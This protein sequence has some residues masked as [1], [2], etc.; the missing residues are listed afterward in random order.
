[1]SQSI[2]GLA[3]QAAELLLEKK[4]ENVTILK[5]PKQVTLFNYFVIADALSTNHAQT[6][7][8]HI[9]EVMK[10]A[11][12]PVLALDGLEAGSWVLIDLGTVVVHIFQQPFREY[13]DLENLW[14][15]AKKIEI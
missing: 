5:L 7:G 4:G 1:M 2:I 15:D 13:Y 8:K 14:P 3:R 6:L 9:K 12:E 10:K 11:K